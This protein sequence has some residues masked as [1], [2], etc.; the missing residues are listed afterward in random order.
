MTAATAHVP[1][2]EKKPEIPAVPDN[3]MEAA[4][5]ASSQ[6]QEV[7]YETTPTRGAVSDVD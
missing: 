6:P 7:F 3:K 1:T 4:S 2:P 5:P